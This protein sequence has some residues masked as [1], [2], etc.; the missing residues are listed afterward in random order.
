MV[1]TQGFLNFTISACI[2]QQQQ[3]ETAFTSL[4]EWMKNGKQYLTVQD[5][6]KE[7][8]SEKPQKKR[9]APTEQG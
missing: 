9:V 3:K 4:R 8:S 7:E 5:G 6:G 2:K 1:T